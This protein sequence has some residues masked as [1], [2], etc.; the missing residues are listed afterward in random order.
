MIGFDHWMRFYIN[1]WD[2]VISRMSPLHQAFLI[3]LMH[4]E[5]SYVEPIQ[6]RDLLIEDHQHLRPYLEDFEQ[7]TVNRIWLDTLPDWIDSEDPERQEGI[8]AFL[9]DVVSM[10]DEADHYSQ[11]DGRLVLFG[12]YIDGQAKEGSDLLKID[13][14]DDWTYKSIIDA[15]KFTAEKHGISLVMTGKE[16]Y[17]STSGRPGEKTVE[18]KLG[19]SAIDRQVED[20]ANKM[21]ESSWF[22]T[23]GGDTS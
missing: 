9:N 21:A 8:K 17:F 6:M 16:G 5:A 1:S 14:L 11:Q 13:D 22:G 4:G 3:R 15:M 18:H 12:E 23:E 20:F 7:V 2:A 10:T 19:E